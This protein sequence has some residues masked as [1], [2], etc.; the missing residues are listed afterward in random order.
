M[1]FFSSGITLIMQGDVPA[2]PFSPRISSRKNESSDLSDDLYELERREGEVIVNFPPFLRSESVVVVEKDFTRVHHNNICYIYNERATAFSSHK[3]YVQLRFPVTYSFRN[4]SNSE[5]EYA[6]CFRRKTVTRID[7]EG[8]LRSTSNIRI[9]SDWGFLLHDGVYKVS[10]YGTISGQK[11]SFPLTMEEDE[12]GLRMN[13]AG[14]RVIGFPVID[15]ESIVHPEIRNS[16]TISQDN[17]AWNSVDDIEYIISY[18]PYHLYDS[19]PTL[20]DPISVEGRKCVS[21][22]EVL[23]PSKNQKTKK[24]RFQKKKS[25]RY[26][27][28]DNKKTS[29]SSADRWERK[30]YVD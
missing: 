25:R 3:G 1:E 11:I 6:N 17:E 23:R 18:T 12:N 30:S 26:L 20:F 29:R 15:Y 16:H 9:D 7:F 21:R 4:C 5:D 13:F 28:E 2:S 14:K 10:V 8:A 19:P 22:E 24:S 27:L